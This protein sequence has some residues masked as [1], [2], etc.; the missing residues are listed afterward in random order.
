MDLDA[1]LALWDQPIEQRDDPVADFR[2]CYADPVTVNGVPA[3]A[4]QLVQR[5]RALQVAF[6]ERRT[7]LVHRVEA[8][9]KVVIGFYM[10]V[11]HVGPYETAFGR[12]E[13]TERQLRIRVNDILT[14]RDGLIVDIWVMRDDAD[15]LRQLDRL[16]SSV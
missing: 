11:R 13:A 8:G 16:P 4:E 3:T 2:R 1:V 5:A 7:E 14:V 12:V 15:L 10:H 9:D 6:A